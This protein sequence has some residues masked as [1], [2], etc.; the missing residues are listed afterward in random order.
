MNIEN[1]V[2]LLD[3]IIKNASID[4]T[5]LPLNLKKNF[6]NKPINISINQ[7]LMKQQDKNNDKKIINSRNHNLHLFLNSLKK[8]K[9][10][11]NF[12]PNSTIQ[13][14][15]K[16]TK[17]KKKS[18][19]NRTMKNIRHFFCINTNIKPKIKHRNHRS[20]INQN[21]TQIE[22][23]YGIHNYLKS[24]KNID[25]SFFANSNNIK[26]KLN[27]FQIK[28]NNDK[29]NYDNLLLFQKKKYKKLKLRSIDKGKFISRNMN[30][31][32]IN[33]ENTSDIN[34]NILNQTKNDNNASIAPKK[35]YKFCKRFIVN[36]NKLNKN[37]KNI[38]KFL[39]NSL[40]LT[41]SSFFLCGKND[42]ENDNCNIV[43]IS[44][45]NISIS[46]NKSKYKISKENKKDSLLNK[47][48]NSIS[49]NSSFN[50][51]K[52][53]SENESFNKNKKKEVKF[54]DQ[55]TNSAEKT[56]RND[57]RTKTEELNSSN[58]SRSS[59]EKKNK[60]GVERN[61]IKINL[62]EYYK[63]KKQKISLVKSDAK[64]KPNTLNIENEKF[65]TNLKNNLN[66]NFSSVIS[67][68]KVLGTKLKTILYKKK[69]IESLIKN[70]KK[71][72]K[73]DTNDI[74]IKIFN[75]YKKFCIQ[76]ILSNKVSKYNKEGNLNQNITYSG[77]FKGGINKY[78][79]FNNDFNGISLS[80][81]KDEKFK[82]RKA[83]SIQPGNFF[84]VDTQLK[85]LDK[86]SAD[87]QNYQNYLN[88]LSKNKNFS[89]SKTKLF[90]FD[91]D[92][93]WKNPVNVLFILNIIFRTLAISI[94]N[95]EKDINI[96]FEKNIENKY[97]Y[98]E[99]KGRNTKSK[100]SSLKVL[101]SSSPSNRFSPRKKTS[102]PAT[103]T[104][105]KLQSKSFIK[106]N[107]IKVLSKK[108]FFDQSLVKTNDNKIKKNQ[109][110]LKNNKQLK[111][112]KKGQ[113]LDTEI[114][115]ELCFALCCLI[116]NREYDLF[117][118]KIEEYK[119]L[120]DI[121]Y[122]LND[123]NTFLIVCA[124]EGC[125]NLIKFLCQ[126]NCDLNIQNDYG[127]TALHYAVAN[128][129]YDI[130]DVLIKYGARE[131]IYNFK[132]LSPWDCVKHNL[133]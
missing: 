79:L 94:N 121:N 85:T 64:Q 56:R 61:F 4:P 10:T 16:S 22:K 12:V 101:N 83:I 108:N 44:I 45:G 114:I 67:H 37:S 72:E 86:K 123:G 29:Q 120:I 87:Y 124:K 80:L 35:N 26:L 99:C 20:Q 25:S 43:N 71:N 84:K 39:N 112:G 78:L 68:N 104:Y 5:I 40:G 119:D 105:N 24:D 122:K 126:K 19:F 91:D 100:R 102:G 66:F 133:D 48:E 13:I 42:K 93:V 15:K 54:D 95:K 129:F 106:L 73:I 50:I 6:T 1:E 55:N 49:K 81:K 30:N 97:V 89:I 23:L 17:L 75:E 117:L 41:S 74:K 90:S 52:K 116:T 82:R 92:D 127:N 28:K 11:N 96:N 31:S 38:K 65:Y 18:I 118:M 109:Y 34:I 62:D 47:S 131:D 115:N 8:S 113:Y 53:E 77:G 27:S 107:K 36:N 57:E 76:N 110:I 98:S 132:G 21:R 69:Q 2:S 128:Q 14:N 51:I 46:N 3:K 60:T 58:R 111:Y 130:V 7:D 9:N 33:C 103:F 63:E 70:S 32:N 59:R 125:L 88:N